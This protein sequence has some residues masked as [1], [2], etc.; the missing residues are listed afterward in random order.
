V[1]KYNADMASEFR[2]RDK[3]LWEE[4]AEDFIDFVRLS[5]MNGAGDLLRKKLLFP[6][7]IKHL[8]DL[9]GKRV[10]DGGCG[11]GLLTEILEQE[12][13]EVV[14]VDASEKMIEAARQRKRAKDLKAEF[15]LAPIEQEEL[16]P[17]KSFDVVVVNMV[18]QEMIGVRSAFRG[19]LNYLKPGG[20]IVVSV[21][22]PCFDM[23]DSQRT[24]LG[25]L[26]RHGTD[27][28]RWEFDIY[29]PYTEIRRYERNYTFSEHPI[30]Y[31]F[32]PLQYYMSLFT[33]NRVRITGFYEPTLSKED[34][35][36]R[37]RHAYFIPR[38]VVIG[39]EI[40]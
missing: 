10:L 7:I 17:S 26:A 2:D 16:V 31:Y 22:H 37:I 35:S 4:A 14:G 15:I 12:G 21:L 36:A 38:F 1:L 39:G 28:G 6:T 3:Q 13:A 20:Q 11:D 18:F 24:S 23:N 27:S 19:L 32:R 8:G 30:A 5:E 29:A 34:A 40:D 9:R 33:N 25:N